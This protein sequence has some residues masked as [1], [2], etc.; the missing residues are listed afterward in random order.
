MARTVRPPAGAPAGRADG[1]ARLV[2]ENGDWGA[3]SLAVIRAVLDSAY[4]VLVD[5]FATPP[6]APIRIVHWK[7]DPR[8]LFGKRPYEIRLNA[9]HTYWS[10]YVYQFSHELCHV[11]TH[12]D[13][14]EER[15]RHRWFEESLCELASLFVLHRLAEVW[16]TARF[17]PL[18]GPA[19]PA[20][21]APHH[22]TYAEKIEAGYERPAESELPGWLARNIA[23]L[24]A[25]PRKRDLNGTV[26]AVLLGRFRRDPILWRECGRIN[27][28]DPR[29][30]ATFP[31]YLDSW[32]ER[33][34]QEGVGVAR[35]PA[36]LRNLFGL[37]PRPAGR[38]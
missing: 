16:K 31:G 30:D 28:W 2:V 17:D 23:A 21:F 15:H 7:L 13:R 37:R 34:R 6:D 12:F 8:A 24:E 25:D 33:L 26:A 22:A 10:Q 1:G 29:Q 11:L 18:I 32:E 38:P 27:C 19:D 35:T 20:K 4:R 14:H 3:T 9:R 5:A 36:L